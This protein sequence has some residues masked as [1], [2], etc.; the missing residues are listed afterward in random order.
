MSTYHC[1]LLLTLLYFLGSAYYFIRSRHWRCP[2]EVSNLR[3][4]DREGFIELK[5]TYRDEEEE[6]GDDTEF[7]P[8]Q[9]EKAN[10]QGGTDFSPP[11]TERR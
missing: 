11:S 1:F 9:D 5:E 3:D 10:V 2:L 4:D 8:I 7:S 6:E